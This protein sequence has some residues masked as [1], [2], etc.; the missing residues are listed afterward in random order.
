MRNENIYGK[1]KPENSSWLWTLVG[2]MLAMV[3][4]SLL[5]AWLIERLA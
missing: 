1:S 4:L 2:M 3:C 5:F